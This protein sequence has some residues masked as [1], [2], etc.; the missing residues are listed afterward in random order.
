MAL[1]SCIAFFNV[2]LD[3]TW[4]GKCIATVHGVNKTYARSSGLELAGRMKDAED[5]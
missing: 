3:W 1:I 4:I 2:V 5:G